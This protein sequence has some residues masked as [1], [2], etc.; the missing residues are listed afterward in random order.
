M[1]C[2]WARP[3]A[4]T[5]W[6]VPAPPD[7]DPDLPFLHT[8]NAPGSTY[9]DP[10]RRTQVPVAFRYDA[11]SPATL[12]AS[13]SGRIGL[14][15]VSRWTVDPNRGGG[16]LLFGDYELLYNSSTSTWDLVNRIDFPLATFT[17]GNVILTIGP[18]TT[19]TLSGDLVGSVALNILLA[20][21][22]GEDF[23]DFRL[24]G[25]CQTAAGTR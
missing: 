9:A 24:E 1:D 20:G 18:A 5:C 21:G 25:R 2:W 14:A 12:L 3:R 19:F 15:G 13:A 10:T 6:D 11:T 16:Q 8:L 17:L 22:L 7:F 23:G 4:K